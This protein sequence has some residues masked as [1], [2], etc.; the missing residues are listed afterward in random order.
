M[1]LRSFAHSAEGLS[2][3]SLMSLVDTRALD[4]VNPPS[5]S[6][7]ASEFGAFATPSIVG[8]AEERPLS[9]VVTF[10]GPFSRALPPTSG[11]SP[12]EGGWWHNHN[13]SDAECRA[14]GDAVAETTDGDC[15]S[16]PSR[17]WAEHP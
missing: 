7:R 12:H 2:A 15:R 6:P 17:L 3:I 16:Y 14:T 1:A 13:G 8:N 11:D 10:A 4:P 5:G 9:D